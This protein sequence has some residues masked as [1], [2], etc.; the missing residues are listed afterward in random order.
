MAVWMR[1]CQ[2]ARPTAWLS[3]RNGSPWNRPSV[4]AD[5]TW[6]AQCLHHV[7]APTNLKKRTPRRW[8]GDLWSWRGS[9][10]VWASQPGPRM[11]TEGVSHGWARIIW[12]RW[13]HL[14]RGLGTKV[15]LRDGREGGRTWTVF[16]PPVVTFPPSSDL[17]WGSHSPSI[18]QIP[19]IKLVRE[20]VSSFL[21]FSDSRSR[22]CPTC[23]IPHFMDDC[24]THVWVPK[25]YVTTR[26]TQV[27]EKE[28]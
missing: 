6:S 14:Q 5:Y 7:N 12:S 4:S 19:P 15:L 9:P 13:S 18:K 22:W 26:E 10:R 17:L 28:V 27:S 16:L 24:W 25:G 3:E 1:W 8:V 21:Q 2:S 23:C 20:G 11:A